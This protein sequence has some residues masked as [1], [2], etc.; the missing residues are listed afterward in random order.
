MMNLLKK[1]YM[2]FFAI[3]IFI[4]IFCYQFFYLLRMPYL[5]QYSLQTIDYT[6]LL[7]YTIAVLTIVTIVYNVTVLL[8]FTISYSIRIPRMTL[9]YS[10]KK[11]YSGHSFPIFV[12]KKFQVYQV[13]RC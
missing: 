13:I 9:P 5:E 6:K 8:T 12:F 4:S 2:P 1:H 7:Y 11:D 3:I 10:F